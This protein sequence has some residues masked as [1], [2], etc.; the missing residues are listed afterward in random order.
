MGRLAAAV[1]KELR[2]FLR[3][4][5]VIGLILFL[6]TAEI[7]LCTLALSFDV[8][9]LKLAIYD[10]IASSL[11]TV[12][13]WAIPFAAVVAILAVFIREV[14]LRSHNDQVRDEPVLVDAP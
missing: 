7:A 14:A 12:F 6:Y 13:V 8:R 4:R 9:N 10:G 11:A 3:D 5:L 2:Q 1:R